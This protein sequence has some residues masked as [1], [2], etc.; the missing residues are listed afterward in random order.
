MDFSSLKSA[1]RF[2]KECPYCTSNL[3][4]RTKKHLAKSTNILAPELIDDKLFFTNDQNDIGPDSEW[5]SIDIATGKIS[6]KGKANSFFGMY[7]CS[8]RIEC[9]ECN[10]YYHTF[11]LEIDVGAL[12]LEKCVLNNV[13]IKRRIGDY[14]FHLKASKS[15]GETTLTK[16]KLYNEPYPLSEETL[17]Y[18]DAMPKDMIFPYVEIDL[19]DPDKTIRRLDA[20]S[21]F[22]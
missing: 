22:T 16:M 20:L 19:D 21:I 5:I 12:R 13:S 2:K 11:N 7:F 9:M 14:Q 15:F 4:I 6:R 18:K 3:E 1:I 8:F 10:Q 17:D